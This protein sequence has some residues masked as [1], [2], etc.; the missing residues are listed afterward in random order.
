LGKLVY[1]IQQTMKPLSH[2][3]LLLFLLLLTPLSCF[4]NQRFKRDLPRFATLRSN[5]IKMRV[6]PGSEYPVSWLLR[7]QGLPVKIV[8]EYDTWR[9]IE[10]W[11]KTTGWVHQNMLSGKRALIVIKDACA[12]LDGSGRDAKPKAKLKL[13]SLLL[14]KDPK[15]DGSR[16]YVK[17]QGEKGWVNKKD[18]WGLLKDE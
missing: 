12:L 8:A 16:C 2:K 5:D 1:D 11:D 17:I 14:F 18:I 6:G 7:R 9:Q 13:H 15:C 3:T 4:S 10:C